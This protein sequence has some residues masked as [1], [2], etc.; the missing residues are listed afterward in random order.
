L[1]DVT[2][3]QRFVEH[4]LALPSGFFR[5]RAVG[6][7]VQ[8]AVG[9]S[10]VGA[11]AMSLI[12]LSLDA[13]L[14]LG[15]GALMIAYHPLLA[16]LT[17]CL[18][19]VHLLAIVVITRPT[20]Q[21]IAAELAYAGKEAATLTEA[22][23]HPEQ[24][25][26]F[27]AEVFFRESYHDRLVAR[28]SRGAAWRRHTHV[29]GGLGVVLEAVTL[30][31]VLWYGG[32]QVTAGA[33][34][35]GALAAFLALQVMLM[36][37][38]SAGVGVAYEL[39]SLQGA[40]ERLEDV[41]GTPCE[42]SGHFAPDR[43]RGHLRLNGVAFAY[44]RGAASLFE[45]LDFEVEPG[46]H[47]AIVGPS[48]VGKS[49]VLQLL[50]G[51]L[52]PTRGSIQV[53]GTNLRDFDL[54]CFRR[55]VGVVLQE[56]FF[57]NDTVRANLCF[58][59]CEVPLE[60]LVAAARIAC[61]DSTIRALPEGYDTPLGEGANRLSGGERQRLALARALVKRPRILILD[62]AT[63]ALDPETEEQIQRNLDALDITRVT[64]AHRLNTVRNAH[65]IVVLNGGRVEQQGGYAELA[66]AP[67]LFRDMMVGA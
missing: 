27:E 64:I 44:R 59:G 63:S 11:F 17:I 53:D 21:L 34:T 54:A 38:L 13:F 49:T 5:Q 25:R 41:E 2:L 8:R 26:A 18:N 32:A 3:E 10:A 16:A 48:G 33:L 58:D 36:R 22:L 7:L 46:Q 30:A 28:L 45:N 24:V 35:P 19:C 40:L 65:R 4:L 12:Q 43:L 31:V 39:S 67:G 62:E 60:Q 66:R 51:M 37:P 15:F 29:A 57:I 23:H 52:A 20:G 14:V 42:S 1:L 55:S 61:I 50:L 56:P 6:D 9:T 47:L